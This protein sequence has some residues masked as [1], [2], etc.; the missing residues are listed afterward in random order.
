MAYYKDQT[1]ERKAE[2]KRLDS[3]VKIFLRRQRR[4]SFRAFCES[5]DPSQGINKI[6]YTL[7]ALV[8]RTGALRTNVLT[9]MNSFEFRE[10]RDDLVRDD[11]PSV[12]IPLRSVEVVNESLDELFT[13]KEFNSAMSAY[14]ARSAPGLD[15]VSYEILR[16]FSDRTRSFVLSLFNRMLRASLCPSSWRDTYVIFIP[17]PGE[18]GYRRISL[19]SSMSKLFER[20]VHRRLEHQAEHNNLVP[21]Y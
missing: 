1:A 5:L 19:T 20:M 18:K 2:F 15:G 11:V 4:S 6:W 17:K 12:D 8:S 16:R 10:L 13:R 14:R 3:E 9:D 21:N 7:R